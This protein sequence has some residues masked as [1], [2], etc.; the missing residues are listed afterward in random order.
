MPQ[1]TV[2]EV[3]AIIQYSDGFTGDAQAVLEK[4]NGA[5]RIFSI[6]VTV[7]PDKIGG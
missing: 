2:A 7:P 5:W 3:Q 4:V 6:N 1:G